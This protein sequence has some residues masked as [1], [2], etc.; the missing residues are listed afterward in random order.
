MHACKHADAC[1]PPPSLPPS[2][3]HWLFVNKVAEE[4]VGHKLHA[5]EGGQQGLRGKGC[6]SRHA[7]EG[8]HTLITGH[9]CVVSMLGHEV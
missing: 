9:A 2:H 7:E 4:D 8:Q 5:A 1:M 3:T 6:H